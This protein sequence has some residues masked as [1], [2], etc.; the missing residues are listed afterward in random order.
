[1]SLLAGALLIFALA[2][3]GCYSFGYPMPTGYELLAPEDEQFAK[4]FRPETGDAAVFY[5]H[6]YKADE[7]GGWFCPK[8]APY[9]FSLQ[10]GNII[11]GHAEPD[12]YSILAVNEGSY[13]FAVNAHRMSY[14]YSAGYASYFGRHN[15]PS[16]RDGTISSGAIGRKDLEERKTY[17]LRSLW[18]PKER[19]FCYLEVEYIAEQ[20]GR[21]AVKDMRVIDITKYNDGNVIDILTPQFKGGPSKL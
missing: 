5:Y 1:M 16:R 7:R 12:R 15:P 8:N 3:V 4:T 13:H 21:E 19:G 20:E 10:L 18:K 6:D 14:P 17:F 2:I 11:V 9:Y